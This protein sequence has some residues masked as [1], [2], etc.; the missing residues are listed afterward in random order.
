MSFIEK[1]T[2][3]LSVS[4]CSL[5][6]TPFLMILTI[7][8]ILIILIIPIILIILILI[9]NKNPYLHYLPIKIWIKFLWIQIYPSFYRKGRDINQLI[10]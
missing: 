6:R 8:I 10:F 4:I 5:F 3:I 9:I 2:L 1:T 7:L